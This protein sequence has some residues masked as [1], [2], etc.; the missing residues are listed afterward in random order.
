MPTYSRAVGV[1]RERPVGSKGC[2]ISWPLWHTSSGWA[3]PPRDSLLPAKP[4]LQKVWPSLEAVSTAGDQVLRHTNL[5]VGLFCIQTRIIRNSKMCFQSSQ[6]RFKGS[7][8]NKCLLVVLI[9]LRS[10]QRP[11]V[12]C[13]HYHNFYAKLIRSFWFTFTYAKWFLTFPEIKY[14]NIWRIEICNLLKMCRI[15]KENF[16]KISA[17]LEL[18]MFKTDFRGAIV[19]R[20]TTDV[21]MCFAELFSKNL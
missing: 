20:E 14:N 17:P 13:R 15:M 3:P 8:G 4:Q 7:C 9:P 2:S 5:P 11:F 10:F 16:K 21:C 6:I 18:I 1:G 19:L 12:F